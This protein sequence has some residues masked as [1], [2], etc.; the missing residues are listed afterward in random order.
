[1]SFNAT[2]DA[3]NSLMEHAAQSADAVVHS[4]QRLANQAVDGVSHSLQ[5]AGR[6]V[7]DGAHLASDKTVAYIREQPV[8]SVLIAAATGA[9]LVALAH[10][11]VRPGNPQ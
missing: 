10:L 9:A 11:A 6:Q 4:T 5:A 2:P 8:K 1:M 7:R 3:S